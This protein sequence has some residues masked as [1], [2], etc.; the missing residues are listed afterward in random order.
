MK[1]AKKLTYAQ[2]KILSKNGYDPT[3]YRFLEED[4]YAMLFINIKTNETIWIEKG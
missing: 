4:K 3:E 2:K 1:R